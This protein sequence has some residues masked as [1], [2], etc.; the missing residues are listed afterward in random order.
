MAE[1][2]LEPQNELS[3]LNALLLEAEKQLEEQFL[4]HSA[5]LETIPTFR[6]PIDQCIRAKALTVL[7]KDM[8]RTLSEI[9][10][11]CSRLSFVQTKVWPCY[12][13][14]FNPS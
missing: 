14:R 10:L 7:Q 4:V 6:S 13:G 11:L 9:S 2:Y 12:Y 3:K 8:Q 1:S 5:L